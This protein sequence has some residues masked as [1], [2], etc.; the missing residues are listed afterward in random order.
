[1]GRPPAGRSGPDD[2]LAARARAWA[3]RSRMDQGLPAKVSDRQTIAKVVELLAQARQTG[4][5][6]DSSKRL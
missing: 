5:K 2:D 3:E 1:M 6:R 4:V